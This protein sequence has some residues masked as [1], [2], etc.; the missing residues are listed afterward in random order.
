MNDPFVQRR[1]D[2]LALELSR[3]AKGDLSRGIEMLWRKAYSREVTTKEREL[4]LTVAKK[5]GLSPVIW[6]VFNSSEFLDL[7]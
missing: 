7:K 2:H 4:A 3:E 1:S 6:A 5:S